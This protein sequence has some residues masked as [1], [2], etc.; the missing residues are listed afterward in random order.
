MALPTG[1]WRGTCPGPQPFPSHSKQTQQMR[2][3]LRRWVSSRLCVQRGR[4][5]PRGLTRPRL[6]LCRPGRGGSLRPGLRSARLLSALPRRRLL[7]RRLLPRLRL[8]ARRLLRGDRGLRFLRRGG[9]PVRLRSLGR[10]LGL[11]A[12]VAGRRRVLRGAGAIRCRGA[13][14]WLLCLLGGGRRGVAAGL[15]A[16]GLPLVLLGRAT[17]LLVVAGGGSVAAVVAVV[18]VLAV[19]RI[20]IVLPRV[21]VRWLVVVV[22]G[23]LSRG[24][25]LRGRV[26]AVVP[27]PL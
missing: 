21:L 1:T 16:A 7:P 18:P 17:R 12:V 3:H 22:V 24:S 4:R 11:G 8:P 2:A 27:Y 13:G 19:L 26:A 15:V 20:V 5:L 14:L 9:R 6:L 23:V 10:L 25:L